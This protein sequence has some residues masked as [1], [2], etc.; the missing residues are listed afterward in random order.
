[1][2]LPTAAVDPDLLEQL[3][4]L[5]GSA[6]E[7]VRLCDDP[8]VG[9]RDVAQAAHRDPALVARIVQVANSPFYSPREP[10][11]DVA[12]AASILGLRSL[13]M[14]GVGFA[15]LG[16]LW[17]STVRS[18]QLAGVIGASTIAGSGARTFSARIGTGRDEEAHTAGLL[19]F[20]GELA[21]LRS[22]PEK[23]GELWDAHGRLPTVAEQAE[24]FATDGA[25][26]G[27]L[28]MER[29]S[30]PEC[31]R[32][33]VEARSRSIKERLRRTP[34]V[35][36]A[37]LGFGTAIAE[38]L[39]EPDG[40]IER[41]RPA[42]RAWGLTDDELM[43]YWADFRVVVRRTNQQMGL[44]VGRELDSLITAAKDD[45]L[46]SSVH[47]ISELED[48]R[49]EIDQLRSENE[50]LE[51][52]SLTDALTEAPNRAAFAA[53]LRSSLAGLVRSGSEGLVGVAMFDLDNFKQVNDTQGHAVGDALLRA[54]A[55]AAVGAA[56]L[57]EVFA[58]L[59][60]D[61]FAMVMRPDSIDELQGAVD[62]MRSV[63][64]EA[65]KT[66]PGA[67]NA[68]VSAGAALIESVTGELEDIQTALVTAADD[69]L[70]AAKRQ[71]RNRTFVTNAMSTG[72]MRGDL[73]SSN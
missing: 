51:D 20:V 46:S 43:T 49:R 53:H 13:K 65:I 45:Y 35:F 60:G 50:R 19:S 66:V 38:V 5:P 6:I 26:L 73:H 4:T 31:L 34:D 2:S 7:F 48:A 47:A 21:L 15:V 18:E 58:R 14:I 27:L 32:A 29:W 39:G 3:P 1:M 71:G 24:E 70:Y 56:R 63:M 30:I 54:V 16:E 64:N 37:A 52:L 69:A 23:F 25:E 17:G 28:L 10:V 61:E 36:E 12:R 41:L 42:A 55:V 72:L 59:G 68:T 40:A 11:T 8:T 33:G 67:G 44:D 9:A 22:Y 57:N 62:R